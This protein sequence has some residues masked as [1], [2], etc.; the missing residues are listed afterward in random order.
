M[1]KE[2]QINLNCLFNNKNENLKQ[3]QIREISANEL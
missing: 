3:I 2:S 1:G